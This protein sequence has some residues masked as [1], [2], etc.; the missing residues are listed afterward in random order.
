MPSPPGTLLRGSQLGGYSQ[1]DA[2][3]R[4]ARIADYYLAHYAQTL[5]GGD[6]VKAKVRDAIMKYESLAYTTQDC[7]RNIDRSLENDPRRDPNLAALR[8]AIARYESAKV[9]SQEDICIRAAQDMQRDEAARNGTP[10]A[11]P[12]PK[13]HWDSSSRTSKFNALYGPVT[14]D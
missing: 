13:E 7:I 9:M 3:G 4:A 2:T 1:G 11:E 12:T 5:P 10:S 8:R 6:A 14:S